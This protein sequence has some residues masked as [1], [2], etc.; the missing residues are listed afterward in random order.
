MSIFGDV[1]EEVNVF[2]V[3]RIY[4]IGILIIFV[5]IVFIGVRF[6]SK[7]V[8][9]LLVC[10]ILFILCIYI[11]IFVVIEDDNVKWVDWCF[12]IRV[13]FFVNNW[14][15]KVFIENFC[16]FFGFLKN[17]ILIVKIYEYV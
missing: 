15:E 12:M 16:F 13:V 9:F 1:N 5:L 7:F 10:V 4:G 14:K 2:N 17:W 3:Y 6:V 8:V 11:G